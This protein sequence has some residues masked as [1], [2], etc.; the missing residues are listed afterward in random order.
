MTLRL[1][2]LAIALLWLATRRQRRLPPQSGSR[3]PTGW[4]QFAHRR[5][6][7]W[8]PQPDEWAAFHRVLAHLQLAEQPGIVWLSAA[9]DPLGRV[10][11]DGQGDAAS[12]VWLASRTLSEALAGRLVQAQ[13]ARSR[14]AVESRR[15]VWGERG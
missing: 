15:V 10:Y 7:D 3:A 8:P 9:S 11:V 2:L 12:R 1:T 5:P 14:T 13:R 4:S 6:L